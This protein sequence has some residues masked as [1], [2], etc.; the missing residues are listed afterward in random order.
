MDLTGPLTRIRS[1]E[2]QASVAS[3]CGSLNLSL[4]LPARQSLIMIQAHRCPVCEKTFDTSAEPGSRLFPFCSDRCR[5]VDLFR[6]FDG[7]YAVVEDVDPMVA[8]FLKD[9]PD[10]KVQG[11]GMESSGDHDH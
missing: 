6:W 8:E 10:I 4:F 2:R 3:T 5:K 7:R 1:N 9:D 11:E